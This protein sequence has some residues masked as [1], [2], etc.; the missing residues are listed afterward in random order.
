MFWAN[1]SSKYF[2]CIM[3]SD[4]SGETVQKDVLTSAFN[5]SLLHANLSDDEK[6]IHFC[7]LLFPNIPLD[8]LIFP[9]TLLEAGL[10]WLA[11][12]YIQL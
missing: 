3:Y 12:L 6:A 9:N 7:C 4:G 5:S 11:A 10:T 2:V 8:A 1:L